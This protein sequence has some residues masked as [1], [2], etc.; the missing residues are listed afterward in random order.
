MLATFSGDRSSEWRASTRTPSTASKPLKTL[1]GNHFS[2]ISSQ[3]CS[4]GY[5]RLRAPQFFPLS[6]R[7]DNHALNSA[8]KR[9]TVA[10]ERPISSPTR[11]SGKPITPDKT[12]DMALRSSP[13]SLVFLATYRAASITSTEKPGLL[14]IWHPSLGTM[15]YHSLILS[16]S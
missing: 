14:P 4:T 9:A 10:R 15:P 5:A 2:R 12:T 3:R 13:E 8:W 1:F 6:C 16:G 7:P 11:G